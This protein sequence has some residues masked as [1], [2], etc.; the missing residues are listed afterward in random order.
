MRKPTLVY[1]ASRFEWLVLGR[2]RR[3]HGVRNLK[4]FVALLKI[5]GRKLKSPLHPQEALPRL[6]M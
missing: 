5:W 2:V 3:G 1:R 4:K 6:G